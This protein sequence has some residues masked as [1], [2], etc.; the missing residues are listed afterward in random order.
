M[1]I[2]K[3]KHK[4]VLVFLNKI[5]DY[6]FPVFCLGCKKEGEWLCDK[7]FEKIDLSGI[8]D[9]P[10]CHKNT[11]FGVCCL[12][13]G[14]ESFLDKH[15]AVTKYEEDGLVGSVIQTL[16]YSWAEDVLS[17]IDKIISKFVDENRDLFMNIDCVVPVPLHQKRYVE[18]G[19][20]QAELIA[21]ILADKINKP[22]KNILTRQRH[23]SQ[24]AKLGREERLENL[25]DAFVIKKVVRGNILLVDDVFTTGSTIQECA[26]VLKN[27]GVD[28]VVGF[29]LA[30]G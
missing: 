25:K 18:R 20:N 23:T 15:L 4:Q 30:R 10:V 16:K 7:C 12:P 27:S 26:K 6:I 8:F 2:L 14:G 22:L 28:K 13:C 17:A 19:F 24:Q 5:K 9:C 21:K 29:S 11:E 3:Q 1:K